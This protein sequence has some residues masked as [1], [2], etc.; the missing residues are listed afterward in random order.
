MWDGP[1]SVA[2]RADAQHQQKEALILE[3]ANLPLGAMPGA[4]PAAEA[5]PRGLA[6]APT[7]VFAALVWNIFVGLIPVV[8]SKNYGNEAALTGSGDAFRQI[9]F[10]LIFLASAAV[11]AHRDGIARLWSLPLS[12]GLIMAWSW[13]SLTW[14]IEPGVAL[15]RVMLN[16]MVILTVF[17]CIS[18]LGPRRT[19]SQLTTWCAVLL[20]ANWAAVMVF[21]HAKHGA[22]E[23]DEALVGTWRGIFTTKNEAGAFC[24]VATLLLAHAT[25]RSR[26]YVVGPALVLLALVFL[27]MTA[28]KTSLALLI[29][30]A[31]VGGLLSV[32]YRNPAIRA[33]LLASAIFA[34]T[35]VAVF[36]SEDFFDL[37]VFL[38]DP[39]AF[40]GR[41]MLWQ[42]AIQFASENLLLGAGYGSFWAIGSSSP[43]LWHPSEWVTAAINAHNGYLDLLVQLGIPGLTLA[44]LFFV[45][46]PIALL[47]S[48]RIHLSL[49]RWV[50]GAIIVFFILHNLLETTFMDR[51]S[52]SWF[53]FLTAVLLV[54]PAWAR[55]R[56]G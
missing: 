39:L 47:A 31:A 26:S 51:A 49:P 43:I 27:L 35:V 52:S 23:L 17:Y 28:S 20:L 24:V 9:S 19:F 44:I 8:F 53:F 5:P 13:L 45:I 46:R 56:P 7:L 41:T 15:R 48:R 29:A 22:D 37:F 3:Q 40:T 18:S 25:L 38:D 42:A 16:T 36:F 30:A 2:E 33:V 50:L 34:G 12:V 6:I 10:I 14:A 1:A 55:K 4:F 21:G 54:E 32:A 11:V